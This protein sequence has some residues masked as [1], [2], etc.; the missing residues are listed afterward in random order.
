MRH[1]G[2][3]NYHPTEKNK[4]RINIVNGQL[5]DHGKSTAPTE[6]AAP[7]YTH[8]HIHPIRVALIFN[9]CLLIAE[10]RG[11][12]WWRVGYTERQ[13]TENEIIKR[14][15]KTR[16]KKRQIDWRDA[17]RSMAPRRRKTGSADAGAHTNSRICMPEAFLE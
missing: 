11:K 2:A 4:L 16:N 9:R 13:Y 1:Q 17:A 14:K 6:T 5:L 12:R 8:T 15:I 10:R 3:P 7:C